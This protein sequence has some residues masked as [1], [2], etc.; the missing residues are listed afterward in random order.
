MGEGWGSALGGDAGM[1]PGRDGSL[2]SSLGT[3]CHWERVYWERIPPP[4]SSGSV[5]GVCHLVP[6]VVIFQILQTQLRSRLQV[7]R[8]VRTSACL[9][10]ECNP[11]HNAWGDTH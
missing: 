4:S 8:R 10:G 6:R 1:N 3:P 2:L 5:L 9:C 11:A 7:L